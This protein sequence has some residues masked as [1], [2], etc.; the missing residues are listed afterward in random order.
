[1]CIV[2][3][4]RKKIRGPVV[5]FIALASLG[6]SLPALAHDDQS[7]QEADP[8]VDRV[9]DGGNII[10]EAEHPT[11]AT[12]ATIESLSELEGQVDPAGVVSTYVCANPGDSTA[13]VVYGYEHFNKN[14]LK[15]ADKLGT[16]TKGVDPCADKKLVVGR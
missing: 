4:E 14:D 9:D 1:M 6:L 15:S 10:P 3:N 7:S 12:V 13:V 5:G 2:L 16:I 8:Y 11:D